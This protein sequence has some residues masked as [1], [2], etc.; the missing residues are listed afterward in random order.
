LKFDEENQ[1]I[2]IPDEVE[3]FIDNDFDLEDDEQDEQE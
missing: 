1:P 3:D 2:G